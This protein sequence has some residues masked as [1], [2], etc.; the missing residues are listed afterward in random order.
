MPSPDV[1]TFESATLYYRGGNVPGL[2]FSS[3]SLGPQRQRD[4]RFL[5][6]VDLFNEI[7]EAELA[8]SRNAPPSMGPLAST[9]DPGASTA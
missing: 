5:A 1:F 8:A 9:D 7:A 6:F 3:V 2:R 4:P